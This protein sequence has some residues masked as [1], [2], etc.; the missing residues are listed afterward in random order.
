M[1]EFEKIEEKENGQGF[2]SLKMIW[3]IFRRFWYWL[4][5]VAVVVGGS[6]FAVG[7][8]QYVPV[9]SST[10]VF[11]V[12]NVASTT[13]L[14]SAS[15]TAGAEDMAAVICKFTT[16]DGVVDYIS[17]DLKKDNYNI[18]GRAI[19]G[20]VSTKADSAFFSVTVSSKDPKLAYLICQSMQVVLP[21]YSDWANNQYEKN[22]Y[23]EDEN[24]NIVLEKHPNNNNYY[25]IVLRK[26]LIP[27]AEV[28]VEV[29]QEKEAKKAE[30][31]EVNSSDTIKITS[32][33]VQDTSPDNTISLF[34][35]PVLAALIA[36][37]LLYLVFFFI[38]LNDTIIYSVADL[39]AQDDSFPVIGAIEH[40][41]VEGEDRKK[42]RR[43]SSKK[44]NGSRVDVDKKLL[45]RKSVPFRITEAFHELRTNITFCAAGEAGCVIGVASSMAGSGKSFVM[46]NLAV[47]LSSLPEKKILLVDSDMRCPMI[48]KIFG[49]ENKN[50]LSNLIAGQSKEANLHS[51]GAL[52]V[53]T[54]GT[55][56]PNPIDLLSTS[57]MAQQIELWKAQYD[58][59]LIDLPPIGEVSD[60]M[61]VS[62]FISGYIFVL[63]SGHSDIRV[64]KDAVSSM[65]D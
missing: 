50:G 24:G 56:P 21:A 14:Y 31:V 4:L 10:S 54:S 46:A 42:K 63:R 30:G 13:S 32:L 61:V 26:D 39:K 9:Y 40:W 33:A 5:L 1:T 18:S 65:E 19:K 62:P 3:N 20:M 47:S 17:Q 57:Q 15:Q 55:L 38:A 12:S 27:F 53:L 36:A 59:V 35:Y 8:S 52:D 25:Q 41:V 48:H 22:I 28:M 45:L 11:Y 23:K 2:I 37:V 6:V 49:L 44:M 16:A 43:K 64:L 7:Y 34:Q 58:Y 60:A 29:L 51:F